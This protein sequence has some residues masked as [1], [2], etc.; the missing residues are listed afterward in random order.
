MNGSK[1][2]AQSGGGSKSKSASKPKRKASGY[3]KFVKK[4]AADNKGKF[5]GPALMKNAGAKWSSMSDPEKKK[6]S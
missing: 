5:K 6:F 4:F 1:C 2:G 3:A